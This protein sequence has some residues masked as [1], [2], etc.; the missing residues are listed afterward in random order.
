MIIC[1][2]RCSLASMHHALDLSIQY[3]TAEE[4]QTQM[5]DICFLVMV[6]VRYNALKPLNVMMENTYT[7]IVNSEAE[8]SR[9]ILVAKSTTVCRAMKIEKFASNGRR[10]R[11]KFLHTFSYSYGSMASSMRGLRR[12][13]MAGTRR[14]GA[15]GPHSPAAA[16]GAARRS[17]AEEREAPAPVSG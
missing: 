15:G 9:S 12:A 5:F 8:G 6:L 2:Q 3:S 14:A 13:S 11:P 10:P 16:E 17:M 7:L 1:N 4:F